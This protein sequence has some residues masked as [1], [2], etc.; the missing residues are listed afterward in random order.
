MTPDNCNKIDDEID[1]DAQ[2]PLCARPLFRV[3]AL[4]FAIICERPGVIS[5]KRCW[6]C[7]HEA[8]MYMADSFIGLLWV[9]ITEW[10]HD[11]NL[12]G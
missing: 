9:M 5:E 8:W 1:D 7:I 6:V 11:R 4:G 2:D 12:W 3:Q 10:K